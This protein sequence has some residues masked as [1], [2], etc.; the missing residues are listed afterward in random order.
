MLMSIL[1]EG[2]NTVAL[3][4]PAPAFGIAAIVVFTLL[5]VATLAF[6]NAGNRH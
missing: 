3:P 1:A 4:M 6:R 5:L 2:G